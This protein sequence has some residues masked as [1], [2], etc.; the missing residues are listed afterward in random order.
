M[1]TKVLSESQFNKKY[2]LLTERQLICKYGTSAG[3]VAAWD[4]RGRGTQTPK[5][6]PTSPKSPNAELASLDN[7]P[8]TIDKLKTREFS[9]RHSLD[10]ENIEGGVNKVEFVTIKGDGKAIYKLTGDT[11]E[12]LTE[13]YVYNIDKQ[14]G[15]GL[16]PPTNAQIPPPLMAGVSPNVLQARA[17]DC[18]SYDSFNRTTPDGETT[19][20]NINVIDSIKMQI[21]DAITLNIDRHGRNFLVTNKTDKD[22]LNRLIA[23]DNG[24]SFTGNGV[25]YS[26][27][28]SQST[29]QRLYIKQSKKIDF[30]N[31]IKSIRGSIN[32]IN[33]DDYIKQVEKKGIRISSAQ[34]KIISDNIK[35]WQSDK[36]WKSITK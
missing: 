18:K 6:E 13:E 5:T 1:L 8:Q 34:H 30:T 4:S 25:M 28:F 27:L 3:A 36:H 9:E 10:S 33:P 12:A 32:K 31:E 19:I 26:V 15:F 24:L 17:L 16:V 20:E 2:P 29:T 14:L 21:L 35:R 23:I 7:S 11:T 22:G